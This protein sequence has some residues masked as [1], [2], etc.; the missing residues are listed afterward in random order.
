MKEVRPPYTCLGP[1]LA[2]PLIKSWRR[3]C[4]LSKDREYTWRHWQ[5]QSTVGWSK[6]IWHV[7]TVLYYTECVGDSGVPKPVLDMSGMTSMSTGLTPSHP[8]RHFEDSLSASSYMCSHTNSHQDLC[9]IPSSFLHQQTHRQ[10]FAFSA[11]FR[12]AA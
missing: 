10:G 7:I 4:C 9:R 5:Y 1:P 12:S 6:E 8:L 3:H 11:T 2:S